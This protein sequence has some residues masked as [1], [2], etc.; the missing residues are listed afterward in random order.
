MPSGSDDALWV[1][2]IG[3]TL[4]TASSSV[5]QV[6]NGGPGDGVY[7]QVGSSAMTLGTGTTFE[8]NILANTSITLDT[9]AI[10][11]CGRVLAGERGG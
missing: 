9:S 5:V 6:I 10:I 8:G 2:Q 11:P 7:W 4:T 1:F 3:S